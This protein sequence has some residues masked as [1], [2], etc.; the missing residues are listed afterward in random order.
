M[1]KLRDFALRLFYSEPHDSLLPEI[2][3]ILNGD[4]GTPTD[5]PVPLELAGSRFSLRSD[6][7]A[8]GAPNLPDPDF[9][10]GIA[11]PEL[12][13]QPG[14]IIALEE[15]TPI[16]DPVATL[17]EIAALA[18]SLA[19]IDGFTGAAWAPARSAMSASY[20]HAA[21]EAWLDGGAFPALGFTALQQDDLGN[22]RSIGLAALVGQELEIA[23]DEN[24]PRDAA[25]RA[26]LAIRILDF[27]VREGPL[28]S[29][30]QREVEGFGQVAMH[31]DDKGEKINLSW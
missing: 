17:R 27:L 6:R 14:L 31:L 21:I 11:W 5:L 16:V 26:R 10:Y 7:A 29:S 24:A 25:D 3:R 23:A 2:G 1:K 4:A 12:S 19:R 13:G 22:M 28:Q 8:K 20:F 30:Q 15:G 18:L 9:F